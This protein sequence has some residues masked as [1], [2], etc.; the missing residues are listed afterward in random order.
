ME[1]RQAVLESFVKVESLPV[2]TQEVE[3]GW[4]K[5]TRKILRNCT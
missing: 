4:E 5:T 1:G 3:L 2:W